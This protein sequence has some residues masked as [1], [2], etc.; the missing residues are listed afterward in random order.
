MVEQDAAKENTR[1]IKQDVDAFLAKTAQP[2][3]LATSSRKR[4]GRRKL[5]EA[6]FNKRY[7]IGETGTRLD[8]S[9]FLSRNFTDSS[10]MLVCESPLLPDLMMTLY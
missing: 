6:D 9:K 2:P 3:P 1:I 5:T 10:M 8:F 7:I 4:K